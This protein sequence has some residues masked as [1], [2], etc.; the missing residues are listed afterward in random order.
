MAVVS[1]FRREISATFSL[2]VICLFTLLNLGWIEASSNSNETCHP[3]CVCFTNSTVDCSNKALNSLPKNLTSNSSVLWVF[4]V[5][6]TQCLKLFF[7]WYMLIL[8]MFLDTLHAIHESLSCHIGY[9]IAIF[10]R[11]Q[12]IKA[13]SVFTGARAP[14]KS[15]RLP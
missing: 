6:I 7:S 14:I 1:Y 2:L 8:S 3:Q 5:V 12:L 11:P 10:E 4:R 13:V 15:I 9:D